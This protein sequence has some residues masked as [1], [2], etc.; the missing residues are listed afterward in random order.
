MRRVKCFL[1]SA[2]F[3]GMISQTIAQIG[4]P[5]GKTTGS[6]LVDGYYNFNFNHPASQS[7]Q[8]RNFDANANQFGLNMAKLTVE[9]SAEP[10]GFRLDAG[11]GKAFDMIHSFDSEASAVRNIE[12]A[13]I[14]LQP[15][16]AKGLQV[17]L[18]KFVTSAGAEVI[19]TDSNWNYSRSLL[20][21][22]AI[23]YYHMGVRTALPIGKHFTGGVQFVNNWNG[24]GDNNTGK[25]IGLS[26]TLA[27]GAVSWSN[28]YYA[29]PEK[30]GTNDG[31]RHLYDTTVLVSSSR[32]S[33]YLN[34]DYGTDKITGTR[35][36]NVW[37]GVAGAAR[38]TL[39]NHIAISPR[40]EWFKDRDG[41]STGT[42]QTLQEFTLTGEYKW[43]EGLLGRLEYRRDWS[44]KPYFDR[45]ESLA[46]VKNQHTV[47]LGFIAC[48]G[49]ER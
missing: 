20:F 16:N 15:A 14:R 44:N 7:N 6:A 43:T 39:T 41:F 19:E 17:D 30:T 37:Y 36:G 12:Q 5:A 18:G 28:N 3:A 29:G 35:A 8:L 23:P 27:G 42:A 9:R 13:Y 34:L 45:G 33:T 25:T 49:P 4:W 38:F 32:I 1:A 11:F 31:W 2:V 26:G 10:V 48:F 24:V 47:L 21:A 22:W 40:L 46:A